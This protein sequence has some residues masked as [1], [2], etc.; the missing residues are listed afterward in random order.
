MEV[1]KARNVSK[2]QKGIEALGV[3]RMT[4]VVTPINFE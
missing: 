2:V 3:Y 1:S 4:E